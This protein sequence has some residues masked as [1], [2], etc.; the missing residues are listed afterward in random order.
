MYYG[1]LPRSTLPANNYKL[2]TLELQ[3]NVSHDRSIYE[4]I[5]PKTLG[6]LLSYICVDCFLV[7]G[8]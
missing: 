6:D 1:G 7:C 3:E 5:F 8:C 2:T 4:D